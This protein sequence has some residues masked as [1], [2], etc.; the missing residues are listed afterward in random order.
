MLDKSCWTIDNLRSYILFYKNVFSNCHMFGLVLDRLQTDTFSDP[1][2]QANHIFN[3]VQNGW[4]YSGEN[5][6]V[7]H[8]NLQ[9]NKYLTE[10]LMNC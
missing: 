6:N 9:G 7:N 10:S 2:P 3:M 5:S 8:K 4:V 1:C